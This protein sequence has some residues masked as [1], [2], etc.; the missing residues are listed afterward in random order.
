M[1][2][3][4]EVKCNCENRKPVYSSEKYKD[5]KCGHKGGNYIEFAPNDLFRIGLALQDAFDKESQPF[6]IFTRIPNWRTY[7]D[8]YLALSEEERDLWEIE[9]QEVQKF[10]NGEKFMGWDESHKFHLYLEENE[11]LAISIE[12]LS[13]KEALEKTLKDGL[14]LIEASRT[15]KNLIEFYW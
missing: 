15:T 2:K 14:S 4:C 3:W 9:I 5:Y 11:L 1:G 7:D 8:E 10:I 6:E 13:L 12:E